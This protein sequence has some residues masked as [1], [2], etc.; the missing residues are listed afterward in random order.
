MKL[1]R[2]QRW[3]LSNQY[4]IL[5]ALYPDE[6]EDLRHTREALES[7]YEL[8]YP[9]VNISEDGV[10]EEEC[11]EVVD[12]LDMHRALHFSYGRL[13]DKKGIKEGDVRFRG[14]D[15][16]NETKY[17]SYARYFC[18][19]DGGGERF[20]ELDRG[21]GFNSHMPV[22]DMYRRM[23]A[24]WMGQLDR[25][26]DLTKAEIQLVLAAQPYPKTVD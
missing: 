5:E 21:D 16:N 3:T 15:G 11:R 10:T 25:R 12:I 1:T 20:K 9:P 4:R 18:G 13:E 8:A 22:V 14:F 6:A 26:H 2:A 23:L 24:V 19:L 17:L 7:G